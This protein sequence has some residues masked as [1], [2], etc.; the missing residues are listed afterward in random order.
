MRRA[1]ISLN[2]ELTKRLD[3]GAEVYAALF[4]ALPDDTII[5]AMEYK[6]PTELE[7]I[8]ESE[9][10]KEVPDANSIPNISAFMKADYN[11]YDGTEKARFERLDFHDILDKTKSCNH[12]WSTYVGFN[13][14]EE[15]C[16]ICNEVKKGA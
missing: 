3:I 8:V 5:R 13:K 12:K 11:Y 15:Y 9:K 14:T 4:Q 7:I 1:K 10:F 6:G 2:P 16:T